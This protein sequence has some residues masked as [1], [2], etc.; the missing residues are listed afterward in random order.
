MKS[1]SYCCVHL[2]QRMRITI[3]LF[4]M[5]NDRKRLFSLEIREIIKGI[6]VVIAGN[7]ADKERPLKLVKFHHFCFKNVSCSS[8]R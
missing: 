3:P 7:L 2:I 1:G 5:S 8:Q 4:L 6:D